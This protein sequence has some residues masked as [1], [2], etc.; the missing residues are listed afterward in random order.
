MAKEGAIYLVPK[1]CTD[2][3]I[4]AILLSRQKELRLNSLKTSPES[5]S[6]TYEREVTFSDKQWEAR[7]MNPLAFT[8]AAVTRQATDSHPTADGLKEIVENEWVGQA[9]LV[10]PI[11]RTPAPADSGQTNSDLESGATDF[12]HFDIHGLYVLPWA[13]GF[14]LGKQL[15]RAAVSH[16]RSL[17][18]QAGAKDVI[19]RVSVVASNSQALALYKGLGFQTLE[20]E[21]SKS[22]TEGI[23]R[24][25]LN[26]ELHGA[27]PL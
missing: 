26:M 5:F 14:G 27:A 20:P 6:S 25:V 16:A 21:E 3:G 18:Q 4:W 12:L 7:L 23:G 22:A 2:L 10:G 13:R 11:H 9:V 24:H 1:S 17:S 8:F 19:V 15:M